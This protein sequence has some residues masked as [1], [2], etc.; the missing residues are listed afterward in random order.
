MGEHLQEDFRFLVGPLDGGNRGAEPT[1]VSAEDALDLPALAVDAFRAA[2]A[3]RLAESTHH[4]TPIFRSGPFAAPT[5]VER[6]HR[7]PNPQLVARGRVVVFRVVPRVGQ[8]GIDRGTRD[9]LTSGGNQVGSVLGR[10]TGH[11]RR[12]EQVG[13]CID[14]GGQLG[15]PLLASPTPGP[16]NEVTADRPCVVAGRIDGRPSNRWSVDR[17]RDRRRGGG[18]RRY[19]SRT[20]ESVGLFSLRRAAA[21]W[22]V[23]TWGTFGSPSASRRSDPSRSCSTTPR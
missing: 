5:P 22:M 10:A 9:G 6:D 1:L 11:G 4:L 15:P 12:P 20:Q 19:E 21:L 14:D 18:W 16:E 17:N 2:R 23:V 7:G 8:Q 13:R 3:W